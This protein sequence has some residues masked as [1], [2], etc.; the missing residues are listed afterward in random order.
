MFKETSRWS[1]VLNDGIPPID[2]VYSESFWEDN[3]EHIMNGY[4]IGDQKITGDHYWY[5]N[6]WKIRGLNNATGRKSIISP[7]F[8]DMDYEYFHVIQRARDLGKNVCVVK[9]R[10]KG[11]TEKHAAIGGKEFS[12][13]RASQTVFVA[14]LEFY[15][16]M[17]F[18]SCI[19]GLNDLYD[20]EYYKRR[21]PNRDD[22]IK[23]AFIDEVLDNNG[24]ITK[25]SKGYLSEIY[26]IT[27]KNNPQAVSSRSP[28]FIVF[29]E[30]G[31]F[32]GVIET[33]GYVKPSLISEGKQTGMA[34]FVGTGGEMGKGAEELE[35][36]FYHPDEFNCLTFDLSEFDDTVPSDTKKVGY[37]C[38]AWKYRFIDNDGNSLKDISIRD[39][40]Q[41][42]EDTKGKQTEYKTIIADPLIPS[43]SFMIQ[44]GGFFGEHAALM[45]NARKVLLNQTPALTDFIERGK[46]DWV[47]D[48]DGRIID[49]DFIQDLS[50]DVII[51]EHPEWRKNIK[52]K[53]REYEVIENM[54]KGGT[55]SYD[56]DEANTSKSKGASYIY[57]DFVSANYTSGFWVARLIQRPEEAET[58]YENTGKLHYYYFAKNLIEYSNL[59]IFDWYK[60]AGLEEYL[61]ERPEFVLASW[62][63]QSKVENR[64]GIDPNSKIHWLGL[65][66]KK[67][68]SQAFIDTL[69]DVETINAF[70]K[71][72]L[73]PKYNCDI[74]IAASLTAVQEQ[75]DKEIVVNDKPQEH[76]K[77]LLVR[78]KTVNGRLVK[79]VG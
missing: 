11:F 50:G 60:K 29:E 4:S 21:M 33:Y 58:F 22:Y 79:I 75:E 2:S 28:S 65:L 68:L 18:N 43:E 52:N 25:V 38:P 51:I 44:G 41:V 40:M 73:D 47:Y 63:K 57:K 59:R 56:R 3:T 10:Q 53:E 17:L 71:Y 72:V 26:K 5:L 54:Y 12:F 9:A 23:A 7:R 1:P 62:I 19:R 8:L 37:F 30:A 27:A 42:R 32:S 76:A 48:K 15:S 49:V 36:I 6:F 35:Y 74:T 61:R 55:D 66:K 67:L 16:D 46:L 78:Y 20:T 70:L 77:R 13:F 34:I 39:V 14:S 31:V 24:N 64:Y 45:L 69:Y